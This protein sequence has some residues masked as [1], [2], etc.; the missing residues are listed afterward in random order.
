MSKSKF[1]YLQVL[2]L[3]VHRLKRLKIK[4]NSAKCKCITFSLGQITI[5]PNFL[6]R[7]PT[8]AEVRYLGLYPKKRLNWNP[9]KTEERGTNQAVNYLNEVLILQRK[10]KD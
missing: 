6:H 9:N 3:L 8:V 2:T 7:T 1:V 10:A 5:L 4:V